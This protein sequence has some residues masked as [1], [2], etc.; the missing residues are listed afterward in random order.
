MECLGAVRKDEVMVFTIGLDL[1]ASSGMIRLS[2]HFLKSKPKK[3][4]CVC[5]YANRF[6]Q[7]YRRLSQG[8]LPEKGNGRSGKKSETL[9]FP[10]QALLGCFTYFPHL[11]S[12]VVL[13][14]QKICIVITKSKVDLNVPT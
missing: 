4:K 6:P 5:Q 3:G 11:Y 2:S 14:F 13:I 12:T 9:N 10:R 7:G 1:K 8:S